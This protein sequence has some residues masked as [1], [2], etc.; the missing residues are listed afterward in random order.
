MK[1]LRGDGD[2]DIDDGN[3]DDDC[4]DPVELWQ[5]PDGDEG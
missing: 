4:K 2:H 3:G 1:E 5:C